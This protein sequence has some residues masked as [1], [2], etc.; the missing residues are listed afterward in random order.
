MRFRTLITSPHL[1]LQPV[2]ILDDARHGDVG[3]LHVESDFSRRLVLQKQVEKEKALD[4]ASC[5]TR[6]GGPLFEIDTVLL[7]A[8]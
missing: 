8:P 6:V 3:T 7:S 5:E 4:L 1:F 2:V